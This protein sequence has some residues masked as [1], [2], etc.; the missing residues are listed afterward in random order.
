MKSQHVLLHGLSTS[1]H[2]LSDLCNSE[3][4]GNNSSWA[5]AGPELPKAGVINTTFVPKSVSFDPVYPHH[6]Q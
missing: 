3:A 2:L 5:A 1:K 6:S 4:C